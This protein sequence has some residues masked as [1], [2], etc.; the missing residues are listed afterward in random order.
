MPEYQTYRQFF[1]NDADAPTHEE[2]LAAVNSANPEC[3]FSRFVG[4]EK[5]IKKLAAVA[6]DALGKR[7][8]LC[9]ELA[10]AFFGPASSGKTTLFRL[11]AE[12][13]GLPFIEISP[14][15]INTLDDLLEEISRVLSVENVPLIEMVRKNYFALPPCIIFIDEVH[16]MK[17]SIIQG[18]L[19]ATEYKDAM[20]VTETRKT[21]NCYN[22][23]WGIATTDS[24]ELF[25]AFL[26]RFTAVN[27]K[28]LSKSDL[29]KIIKIH[30]PD[31]DDEVCQL[32]AYY[33]SGV[34]RKAL[35]FARY[36]RLVRNMNPEK[37]W[38]DV[39]AEVADNE[40][41]DKFGMHEFHVKILKALEEGPISKHGIGNIIDCKQE[42]IENCIMPWLLAE[43][44]DRPR[45]VTVA[46]G[47]GYVITE[48]GLEQLRIRKE[49]VHGSQN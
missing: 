11:F 4:N 29:A 40:G 37:S 7:N 5:A 14:K 20:L 45:Y 35:E 2:K 16:A 1:E 48:A 26:T 13:L 42:Q 32:V 17:D 46:R 47:Q 28:Y 24:G 6:Y 39:A 49:A 21:V 44:D 25:D 10:F 31:L 38:I 34:P 3:A 19:K 43:T 36:M 30:H 27:L 12:I 9:R 23:C 18:L 41:I 15:S 33:N 8:H 22:V